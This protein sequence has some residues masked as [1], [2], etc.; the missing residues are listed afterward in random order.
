MDFQKSDMV[1][2]ASGVLDRGGP[3]MHRAAVGPSCVDCSPTPALIECSIA[4]NRAVRKG[5]L[6][7]R[8]VNTL[9]IIMRRAIGKEIRGLT[10]DKRTVMLGASVWTERWTDDGKSTGGCR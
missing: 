6:A 9:S 2:D 3:A 7:N 4:Q 8:Q 5:G 10:I 1:Y